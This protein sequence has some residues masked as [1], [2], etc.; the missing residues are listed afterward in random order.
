[1]LIQRKDVN[2]IQSLAHDAIS[3]QSVLEHRLLLR[4]IG[5]RDQ[6]VLLGGRYLGGGASGF[7]GRQRSQFHL[8]FGYRRK[9]A[10]R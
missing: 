4:D 2:F 9:V 5:L 6:Q 10:A 7:N 8:A 3:T 1:M